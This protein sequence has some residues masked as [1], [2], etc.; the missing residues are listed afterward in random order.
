VSSGAA[1]GDLWVLYDP[2]PGSDYTNLGLSAHSH[3]HT[4]GLAY[5]AY[6]GDPIEVAPYQTGYV[7]I[8]LQ[9]KDAQD[10]KALRNTGAV[11]AVEKK[12]DG[13]EVTPPPEDDADTEIETADAALSKTL[14]AYQNAADVWRPA[15]GTDRV[16]DRKLVLYEMKVTNEGNVPFRPTTITDYLPSGLG[17]PEP[18][19]DE[20]EV[21]LPGA[22]DPDALTVLGVNEAWTDNGDGTL[23]YAFPA[24]APALLPGESASVRLVL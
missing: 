8:T 12:K 10:R 9:A 3:I 5:Y 16:A 6:V 19:Y 4:A 24:S 20:S 2:A 13:E 22:S 17:F 23:T 21:V 1:N 7:E 15:S 11:T 14:A 18:A